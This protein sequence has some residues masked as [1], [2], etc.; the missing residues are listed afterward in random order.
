MATVIESQCCLWRVLLDHCNLHNRKFFYSRKPKYL[1]LL[2]VWLMLSLTAL[3]IYR[4]LPLYGI[5]TVIL[6]DHTWL[7]F[8]TGCT[9]RLVRKRPIFFVVSIVMAVFFL[10]Q[11]K[12]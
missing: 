10:F 11:Q 8:G 9:T 4:A 1:S 6:M 12:D 3:L 7:I 2:V 5:A